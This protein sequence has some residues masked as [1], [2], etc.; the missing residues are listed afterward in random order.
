MKLTVV[1]NG[2]STPNVVQIKPAFLDFN[3]A[4]GQTHKHSYNHYYMRSLLAYLTKTH[5]NTYIY[6]QYA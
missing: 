2:M 3:H 6:L 1:P 4:D 5:Q